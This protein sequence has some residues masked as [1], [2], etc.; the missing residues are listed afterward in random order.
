MIEGEGSV[1]GDDFAY[2]VGGSGWAAR[3]VSRRGTK[4]VPGLGFAFYVW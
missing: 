4:G 3:A 1:D 2:R